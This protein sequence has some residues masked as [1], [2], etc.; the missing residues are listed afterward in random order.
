MQGLSEDTRRVLIDIARQY[1]VSEDAA[2]AMLLAVQRGQGTMAQFN[3]GELG[4]SGQ[5][6]LGGMTMVGDMFNY[7]LKNTVDGLCNALSQAL[8]SGR[9]H[10][11]SAGGA[12]SAWWPQWLGSPSSTGAQ[13]DSAYAVFPNHRRL[14]IKDGAGVHLYD[15]GDHFISGVGQQQGSNTGL[16]FSSQYGSFSVSSLRRV[17]EAAPATAPDSNAGASADPAF[18]VPVP[19]AS[20]QDVAEPRPAEP[21]VI[22]PVPPMVKPEVVAAPADGAAI[23]AL[24]EK[25]AALREAGILTE[26]EFTAKKTELLS[27][28]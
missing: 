1:G 19:A 17:D 23:L 24:I 11:P 21:S 22:P 20:V 8:S 28:L 9:I 12:A 14:A 15:T 6:M 26:A 18:P 16:T 4:G 3:I 7:G 2:L 25:L 10:L 27:R 13:N 5:W